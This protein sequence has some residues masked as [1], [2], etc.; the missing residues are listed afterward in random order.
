MMGSSPVKILFIRHGNW[1]QSKHAV[2]FGDHNA[3]L[4]RLDRFPNPVFVAVDVHRK[5]SN[6]FRKT[7]IEKE[8]IYILSRYPGEFRLK[9]ELPM[10]LVRLDIANIGLAGIHHHPLPMVVDEEKPRI[11]FFIILH[12]EFDEGLIL[13]RNFAYQ[14]LNNAVLVPLRKN[15]E[16]YFPE[17]SV[18]R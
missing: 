12:T 2:V 1:L 8:G 16:S 5:K 13:D 17:I 4:H 6:V 18:R 7:A 15:F 9:I 11:A 10:N 3:R 14:V